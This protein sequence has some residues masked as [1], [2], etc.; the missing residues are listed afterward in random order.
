MVYEAM[1]L[2]ETQGMKKTRY[3]EE[4]EDMVDRAGFMPRDDTNAGWTT[5]YFRVDHYTVSCKEWL[6][7]VGEFENLR[8]AVAGG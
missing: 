1:C 5:W 7:A 2:R 3:D 4:L 8:S 6:G